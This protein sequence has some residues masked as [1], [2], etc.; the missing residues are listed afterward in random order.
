MRRAQS[1][2]ALPKRPSTSPISRTAV[3][4]GA[5]AKKK[6]GGETYIQIA[7]L[8]DVNF[9]T[10]GDVVLITLVGGLGTMLSAFK[11]AGL[12]TGVFALAGGGR[13]RKDHHPQRKGLHGRRRG[14]GDVPRPR[15]QPER[16]LLPALAAAVA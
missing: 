1:A 8:T 2:G 13:R 16:G 11:V 4:L 5:L 10:S 6:G 12:V 15:Q 7:T 9:T 14:A 3:V